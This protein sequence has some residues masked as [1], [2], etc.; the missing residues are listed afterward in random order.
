MN[1]V[2]APGR[3]FL[4]VGKTE[5][6]GHSDFVVCSPQRLAVPSRFSAPGKPIRTVQAEASRHP[7]ARSFIFPSISSAAPPLHPGSCLSLLR[8]I[9]PSAPVLCLPSFLPLPP[10]LPPARAL[11]SSPP[12]FRLALSSP[13]LHR[14]RRGERLR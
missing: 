4:W 11:L 5:N 3:V 12:C 7:S 1:T 9:S 8:P 6:F 2:P 14:S 13:V 10:S